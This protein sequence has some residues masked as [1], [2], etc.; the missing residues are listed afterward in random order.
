MYLFYLPEGGGGWRLEG[1]GLSGWVLAALQSITPSDPAKPPNSGLPTS[2][3]LSEV[4]IR[5]DEIGGG[6][7]CSGRCMKYRVTIRGDGVVDYTDFGGEPRDPPGRKSIAVDDVVELLGEFFRARFTET[8]PSY[9]PPRQAVL[10][11]GDVL[12]FDVR[13]TWID[14]GSWNLSLRV[15]DYGKTIHLDYYGAPAEFLR[16]RER[17]DAIG[18]PTAWQ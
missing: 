17:I 5:L 14:S 2:A 10:R 12:R 1:V 13:Q 3:G 7:G 15:G 18:G 16:L 4:E 8:L 9:T 11:D 6:G